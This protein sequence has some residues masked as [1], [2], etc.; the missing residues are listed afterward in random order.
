MTWA[1]TAFRYRGRW[2]ATSPAP[3]LSVEVP[4]RSWTTAKAALVPA[5]LFAPWPR[6][7]VALAAA[8]ILLT[9][10][11]TASRDSL[12]LVGRQLLLLFFGRFVVHEGLDRTDAPAAV[13]EAVARRGIDIGRTE[14]LLPVSAAL[15][16]LVSNVPAVMLLLPTAEGPGAGTVLAMAS[17]LAG[18]PLLVGSI[19]NLIVVDPAG[20]LGVTISW[21]EHAAVGVP[22]TL[23]ALA[24]VGW[25]LAR[26]ERPRGDERRKW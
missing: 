17:T 3:P 8:G 6:E 13:L 4:F 5:F 14:W 2:H 16:T 18:N 12:A 26:A 7:W 22:S 11:R 15:S 24:G 10:R 23:A 9:S 21:R 25:L 19:A 20:R 1:W